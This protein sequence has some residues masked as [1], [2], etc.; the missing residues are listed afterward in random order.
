MFDHRADIRL[1]SGTIMELQSSPISADEIAEREAFYGNM[2]WVLNGEAFAKNIFLRPKNIGA[3]G[4]P[5]HFTFRWKWPRSTWFYAKKPI[6]IDG[7]PFILRVKKIYAEV[8]CGGWGHLFSKNRVLT[9][10]GLRGLPD[11][12]R[13]KWPF[14][15]F[16][17]GHQSWLSNDEYFRNGSTELGASR[18]EIFL[19]KL[20]AI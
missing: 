4:I 9:H 5:S 7:G 20:L 14:E 17:M 2:V 16:Q 15:T 8:P 18:V 6:L 10:S 19:N 13:D 3:D 1:D 11:G 12:E